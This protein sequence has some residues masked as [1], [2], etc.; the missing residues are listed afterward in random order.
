MELLRKNNAG[1]EGG[2]LAGISL[3][4][5]A[6]LRAQAQARLEQLV[7]R[8]PGSI[9]VHDRWRTRLLVDLGAE[10]MRHRYAKHVTEATD[11]TTAQWYAGYA[12]LVAAERHTLDN[13]TIEAE[14]AYSDSIERFLTSATGNQSYADSAHHYAVLALAGRAEIRHLR[15]NSKDAVKDLLQ[16]ADLRPGSLDENDGLKRKPRAIAARIHAALM[17]DS[18]TELAEQLTDLLQ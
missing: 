5:F 15:N 8:F 1:D 11:R 9:T 6:G 14:N 2:M 18:K 3:L 10:R 17:A 16:A 13:R 4:E 7:E 12:A